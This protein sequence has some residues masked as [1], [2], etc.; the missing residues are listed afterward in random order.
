MALGMRGKYAGVM[1][2]P[3]CA[4]LGCLTADGQLPRA[5]VDRG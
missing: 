1:R 4:G 5:L 2:E 3:P